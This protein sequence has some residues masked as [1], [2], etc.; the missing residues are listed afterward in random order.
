MEY[1]KGYEGLYSITR[2]GKVYSHINNK[3][4]KQSH[5]HRYPTVNLYKN[6]V[7]KTFRI[8]RLVA[9]TY[10]P[11][12]NNYPQVNHK[13]E[14]K[15]NNS[16]ENL[17]WC[18]PSYNINYGGRNKKFSKCIKCVETNKIY[19]SLNVLARELGV[20]QGSISYA[21]KNGTTVLGYNLEVVSNAY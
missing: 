1:I 14:N 4:L 15:S 3:F 21:I 20:G 13:D 5:K 18:T 6:K 19:P 10:I 9:E 7:Y 8:H 2:D 16:V 12:P 11:N 17:E